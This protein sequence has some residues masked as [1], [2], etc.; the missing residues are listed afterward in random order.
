MDIYNDHTK[1]KRW[2]KKLLEKSELTLNAHNFYS[3]PNWHNPS[4]RKK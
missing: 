3:E 2:L 4:V 1:K